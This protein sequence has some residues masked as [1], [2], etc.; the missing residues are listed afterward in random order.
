[1]NFVHGARK[2]F[3]YSLGTSFYIIVGRYRDIK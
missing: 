2:M 3:E 1:M